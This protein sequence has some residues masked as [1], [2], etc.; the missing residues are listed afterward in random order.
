VKFV[1]MMH[2]DPPMPIR[3][4]YLGMNILG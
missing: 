2:F 4:H 1:T 3:V